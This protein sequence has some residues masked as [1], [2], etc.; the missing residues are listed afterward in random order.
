MEPKAPLCRMRPPAGCLGLSGVGA[1]TTLVVLWLAVGALSLGTASTA[2]GQQNPDPAPA[3]P[4]LTPDPAPGAAPAAPAQPT[5]VQPPPVQPAP[6]ATGEEAIPTPSEPPTT[7]DPAPAPEPAAPT[8][9]APVPAAESTA[10]QDRAT[11]ARPRAA[12][13][14]RER[15][16]R[17]AAARR[18]AAGSREGAA[19]RVAAARPDSL[20]RIGSLLPSAKSSD[21]SRS[22]LLLL[23]A[24]A[25][26][27]LVIASAS[28]VP[29]TT[30]MMKGQLR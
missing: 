27:A 24:G 3:S 22:G 21:G 4:K 11:L 30:R 6:P 5:P 10:E 14:R 2:A 25:L 19:R 9:P 13:R 8:A 16:E 20:V 7:F 29:V 12:Q 18:K 17:A 15:N 23:A 26:L 28:L 1:S